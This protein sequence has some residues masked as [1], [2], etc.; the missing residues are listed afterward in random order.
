MSQNERNPIGSREPAPTKA[1]VAM[2]VHYAPKPSPIPT[3]K[4]KLVKTLRSLLSF[5]G[6]FRHPKVLRAYVA[7]HSAD[8]DG[9]PRLR[10]CG[11]QVAASRSYG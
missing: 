10:F 11:N 2:P 6:S 7:R 8:G 3:R 9:A 5:P 4:K 1:G